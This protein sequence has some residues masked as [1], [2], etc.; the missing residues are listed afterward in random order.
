M[1]QDRAFGNGYDI[2]FGVPELGSAVTCGVHVRHEQQPVGTADP[3][4][5]LNIVP[6]CFAVVA[7]LELCHGWFDRLRHIRDFVFDDREGPDVE[8]AYCPTVAIGDGERFALWCPNDNHVGIVVVAQVETIQYLPSPADLE[9]PS[10][11]P[12]K[13]IAAFCDHIRDL[14]RLV[15]QIDVG[16]VVQAVRNKLLGSRPPLRLLTWCGAAHDG[17]QHRKGSAPVLHRN[18]RPATSG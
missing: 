2:T 10:A 4:Q 5:R 3:L 6:T 15:R 11:V 13:R 17:E 8:A 1:L 12:A 18:Y 7:R 9:L 16:R 14:C